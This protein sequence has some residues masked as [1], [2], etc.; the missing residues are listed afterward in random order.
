MGVLSPKPDVDVVVQSC[1]EADWQQGCYSS[2]SEALIVVD[3]C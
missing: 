2:S 1:E 3:D